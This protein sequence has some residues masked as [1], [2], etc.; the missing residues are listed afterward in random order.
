MRPDRTPLGHVEFADRVLSSRRAVLG[1][2]HDQIREMAQAILDLDRELQARP[3][4]ATHLVQSHVVSAPVAALL[5]ELV[6]A[7]TE[8][9]QA[10]FGPGE[11]SKTIA[12]QKAAEALVD[13]LRQAKRRRAEKGGEAARSPIPTPNTKETVR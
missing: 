3:V 2:S 9:K 13:R 8:M 7:G 5:N 11:R 4:P 12:F 10:R 6:I 1:V